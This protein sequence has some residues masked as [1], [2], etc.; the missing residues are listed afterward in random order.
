LGRL[1]PVQQAL[2]AQARDGRSLNNFRIL[3]VFVVMKR[4]ALPNYTN[5]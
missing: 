1:K 4:S 5:A 2:A 3:R